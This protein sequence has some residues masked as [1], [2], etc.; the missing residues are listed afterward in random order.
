MGRRITKNREQ[1]LRDL[2]DYEEKI[3]KQIAQRKAKSREERKKPKEKRREFFTFPG[4]PLLF[5]DE[6]EARALGGFRVRRFDNAFAAVAYAAGI[7]RENNER[8]NKGL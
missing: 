5:K 7:E 8:T 1:Y 6:K 2:D 4:C 3:N